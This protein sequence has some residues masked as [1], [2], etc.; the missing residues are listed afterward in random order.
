MEQRLTGS[1]PGCRKVKERV[2]AAGKE[3]LGKTQRAVVRSGRRRGDKHGEGEQ[4]RETKR[5][6]VQTKNDA[7][8]RGV[9]LG[10]RS[11]VWSKKGEQA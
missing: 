11:F 3:E 6:K 10:C 1:G 7:G 8:R 5:Q 9:D 2:K 4:N